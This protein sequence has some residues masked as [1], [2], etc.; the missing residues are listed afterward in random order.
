MYEKRVI[1][2]LLRRVGAE[3]AVNALHTMLTT[4]IATSG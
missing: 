1:S 2:Y 3:V 4:E